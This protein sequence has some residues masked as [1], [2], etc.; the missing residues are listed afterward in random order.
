MSWQMSLWSFFIDSSLSWHVFL[1]RCLFIVFLGIV[2]CTT[3]TVQWEW[4]ELAIISCYSPFLCS[5]FHVLLWNLNIFCRLFMSSGDFFCWGLW[6]P[7][8]SVC[9]IPHMY[10][11]ISFA[12]HFQEILV[13]PW[14]MI[15]KWHSS[16]RFYQCVWFAKRDGSHAS[17]SILCTTDDIVMRSACCLKSLTIWHNA[18]CTHNSWWVSIQHRMPNDMIRHNFLVGIH[19][20]YTCIEHCSLHEVPWI[21]A[22]SLQT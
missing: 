1:K 12:R 8:P 21:A 4:C 16:H 19:A 14:S 18:F 5:G 6:S 20:L 17:H 11:I 10:Y 15:C 7:L 13:F 2:S 9:T 22:D 3:S